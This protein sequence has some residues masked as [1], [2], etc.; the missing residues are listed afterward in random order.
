MIIS[1]YAYAEAQQGWL[2]RVAAALKD[3]REELT[4]K[5]LATPRWE[6]DGEQFD[7]KLRALDQR[8][9]RNRIELRDHRETMISVREYDVRNNGR[10]G[11]P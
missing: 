3:E 8:I 5:F 10:A 4:K 2:E 1:L 7:A 11:S 6:R 9:E